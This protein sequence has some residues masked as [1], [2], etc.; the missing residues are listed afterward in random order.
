MIDDA[1]QAVVPVD[2]YPQ[3]L[4]GLNPTELAAYRDVVAISEDLMKEHGP[5]P[6]MRAAFAEWL[7]MQG[8]ERLRFLQRVVTKMSVALS[9]SV[10]TLALLGVSLWL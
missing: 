4:A 8:E 5:G 7:F 3:A 9:V 2:A 6:D 1:D 10:Q